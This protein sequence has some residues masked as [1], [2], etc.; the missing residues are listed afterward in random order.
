MR[1]HRNIVR[2]LEN[3]LDALGIGQLQRSKLIGRDNEQYKEVC[4]ELQYL[5]LAFF[6]V[7][8]GAQR[9]RLDDFRNHYDRRHAA[10]AMDYAIEY[11]ERSYEKI[12]RVDI[13]Y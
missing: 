3:E 8:Y 12:V 9:L 6:A 4:Q 11:I 7:I 1:R 2:N 10:N 13:D 5:N